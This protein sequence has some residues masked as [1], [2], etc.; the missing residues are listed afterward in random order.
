ML[1]YPTAVL[2]L[3]VLIVVCVIHYGDI[4]QDDDVK[5]SK[6]SQQSHS[7]EES[8]SPAK[9]P[10]R[11][12]RGSFHAWFTAVVNVWYDIRYLLVVVPLFSAHMMTEVYLPDNATSLWK[13]G[14]SMLFIITSLI[15][16]PLLAMGWGVWFWLREYGKLK[17][18]QQKIKA[19]GRTVLALLVVPLLLPL[20]PVWLSW[21]ATKKWRGQKKEKKRGDIV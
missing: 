6:S 1:L 5:W 19:F 8:R 12:L 17:L 21:R 16:P 14:S 4:F 7:S 3:P 15:M 13:L 18:R 20:A 9:I 10:F 11:L 2:C